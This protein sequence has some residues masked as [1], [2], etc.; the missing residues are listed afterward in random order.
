[1]NGFTKFMVVKDNIFYS[2]LYKK[3][4]LEDL[5]FWKTLFTRRFD[6]CRY[7]FQMHVSVYIDNNKKNFLYNTNL[8]PSSKNFRP[9]PH[10]PVRAAPQYLFVFGLVN[11]NENSENEF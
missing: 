5:V 4:E 6:I 9:H 1:M 8:I 10:V 3:I 2:S 11:K 7:H